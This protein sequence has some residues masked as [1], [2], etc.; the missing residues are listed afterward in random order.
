MH[1]ISPPYGNRPTGVHREQDAP[2]AD[3]AAE[4]QSRALVEVVEHGWLMRDSARSPDSLEPREILLCAPLNGALH[5]ASEPSGRVETGCLLLI[6]SHRPLG[7]VWA[8]GCELVLLRIPRR[9]LPCGDDSLARCVGRAHPGAGGTASLL[10]SLLRT[11]AERNDPSGAYGHVPTTG[12]RLRNVLADLVACLVREVAEH[13]PEADRSVPGSADREAADRIRTWLNTRLT[14]SRLRPDAVA[15]AHY[16]SVRRLHKLFEGE[17]GTI[18][19]WT[20]Q[21]RL[22]ECRRELGRGDGRTVMVSSVAQRWGFVNAAHFSRA[23]RARFGLSPRAWRELR[24]ESTAVGGPV[25]PTSLNAPVAAADVPPRCP[26]EE[27]T[28]C[29]TVAAR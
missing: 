3:G 16:M 23:F 5:L 2:L 19:R 6:D 7:K 21:R 13:G 22:E 27:P 1:T 18:S 24:A 11:L 8:Q 15:A 10:L 29:L 14:D 9:L 26:S 20:Q 17:S 4:A 25:P 28:A 12:A